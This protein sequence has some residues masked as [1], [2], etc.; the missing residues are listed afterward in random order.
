MQRNQVL[1]LFLQHDLKLY[2]KLT[3]P[4][5]KKCKPEEKSG[6]YV[7]LINGR[8][9]STTLV[10]LSVQVRVC[11]NQV[12]AQINRGHLG[13]AKFNFEALD[14]GFKIYYAE[15]NSQREALLLSL[16]LKAALLEGNVLAP[17]CFMEEDHK[18]WLK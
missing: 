8:E 15:T 4:S 13:N 6:V 10:R 11:I 2:E 1:Q 17:F 9:V 16:K 3:Y 7:I 18:G 12:I 14:K 5:G